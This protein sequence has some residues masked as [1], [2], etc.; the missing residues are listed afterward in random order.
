MN[1][2]KHLKCNPGKLKCNYKNPQG[3]AK[4]RYKEKF[5]DF[6]HFPNLTPGTITPEIRSWSR[7]RDIAN[8]KRREKEKKAADDAVANI[9]AMVTDK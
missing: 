4:H 5:G 3:W 6:P 2:W 1:L 7:S 9:M 8:F